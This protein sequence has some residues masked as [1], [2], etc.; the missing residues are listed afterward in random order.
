MVVELFLTFLN[1]FFSG[2]LF[3]FYC[4]YFFISLFSFDSSVFYLIFYLTLNY[5]FPIFLPFYFLS[6]NNF[7][8]IFIFSS[9]SLL[10]PLQF[11][12]TL[13]KYFF[14]F[15]SFLHFISPLALFT[16][17]IFFILSCHILFFSLCNVLH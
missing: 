13:A 15:L 17:F 14:P 16:P 3:H 12:L 5:I 2:Y 4:Q 8:F 1:A 11:S 10:S 6:I 7:H 9:L